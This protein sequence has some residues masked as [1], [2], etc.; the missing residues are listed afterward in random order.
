MRKIPANAAARGRLWPEV[1]LILMLLALMMLAPGAASA[2]Q[3]TGPNILFGPSSG[4]M[5]PQ[6][7]TRGDVFG[8][9]GAQQK[10]QW[11]GSSQKPAPRRR[12]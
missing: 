10:P 1:A 2:Q 6:S 4:L 5:S 11:P 7:I 8:P 9:G 3:P 12:R